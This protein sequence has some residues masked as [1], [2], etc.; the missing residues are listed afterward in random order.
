MPKNN[1]TNY[2]GIDVSKKY[3]DV[4]IRSTG[5]IFRTSNDPIGFK[6]LKKKLPTS[7]NSL[8]AME[9]TGG[10]ESDA[11]FFLQKK[12]FDV[13]VTNPRQVRDFGKALGK[14]AK[15]DK[16]DAVIIAHYAEAIE[17]KPKEIIAEE[18]KILS[19][20]QHRRKQLV[21][22]LTMEKNRFSKASERMKKHL[23]KTIKFLE[24]QLEELN[25]A[26]AQQISENS[27]WAE[28]S[29]LLCS[30]KGVGVITATTLISGLPELGKI[31]HKEI[32]ALV[33]VAPLNRDSGN[34]K[35]ERSTWGGRSDVRTALYMA[36]LVAVRFNPQIKRFYET[37]CQKGKKKKVALVACMRKLLTILNAMIKNRVCWTSNY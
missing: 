11:V 32:A 28:K 5:E 37:L 31:S 21:E 1:N 7:K 16:I 24:K 3:L 20:N 14:L 29:R 26:L 12:G 25:N 4:C 18:D 17:P 8:I 19:E 6:E 33:G 36:A 27:E 10:Y 13:A 15:T 34:Y 30:T 23:Q 2:I 22:M 9:A 35:G